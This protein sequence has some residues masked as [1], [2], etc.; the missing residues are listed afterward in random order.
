MET[1]DTDSLETSV[2][3]PAD[4]RDH[5]LNAI[6][7]SVGL[8]MLCGAVAGFIWGGIGGRIAMRV[9]FLTS[10]ENVKGLTSDDGFEIG[11]IS[12]DTVFLL[13]FLTV[14]GGMA[15]FLLGLVRMFTSGPTSAVAAGAAAATGLGAGASIVKT[16]G[17]DFVFLEPLGLTVGIFVL[18]P[19]LWGLTVVVLLHVLTHHRSLAGSLPTGINQPRWGLVGWAIIAA[20]S[21]LGLV[22]LV[23]DVSELR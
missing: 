7:I 14:L 13:I 8:S 6:A 16:H 11:T 15:G 3:G 23:S 9:V 1:R 10:S 5:W 12:G 22:D 18:L 4:L 20:V 19:A 21:I 2:R 17:V